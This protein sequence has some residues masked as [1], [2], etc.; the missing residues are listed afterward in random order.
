MSIETIIN[1]VGI[2]IGAAVSIIVAMVLIQESYTP[3]ARRRKS[4]YRG[5]TLL[6]CKK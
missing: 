1:I 3:K 5:K 6:P 4:R 2:V